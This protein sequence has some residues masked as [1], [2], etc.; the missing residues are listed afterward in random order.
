MGLQRAGAQLQ[1]QG[2]LRLVALVAHDVAS[3]TL[4]G[5][6]SDRSSAETSRSVGASPSLADSSSEVRAAASGSGTPPSGRRRRPR[7]AG[8]ALGS[9]ARQGKPRGDIAQLLQML[10]AAAPEG[11]GPGLRLHVPVR[12][13]T[14]DPGGLACR[15]LQKR[16]R[17]PQS[18]GRSA[19]RHG[20]WPS[21]RSSVSGCTGPPGCRE[22]PQRPEGS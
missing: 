8:R 5:I 16:E 21:D 15:T 20:A 19:V 17:R 10:L 22:A 3:A 14:S 12:N 6:P 7:M 18:R 4:G 9:C 2:P 1:D 11:M 13:G